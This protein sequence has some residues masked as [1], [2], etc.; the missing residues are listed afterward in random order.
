[1]E[2]END[3]KQMYEGALHSV[4]RLPKNEWWLW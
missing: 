1:M 4:N 2:K 3:T